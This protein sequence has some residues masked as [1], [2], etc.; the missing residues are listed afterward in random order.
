MREAHKKSYKYKHAIIVQCGH[1]NNVG[2]TIYLGVRTEEITLNK[3]L[4]NK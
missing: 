2:V 3:T 4:S 1:Y